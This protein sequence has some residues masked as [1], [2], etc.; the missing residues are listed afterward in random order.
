MTWFIWI[1][2]VVTWISYGITFKWLQDLR[3]INRELRSELLA[4][5]EMAFLLI[6][7]TMDK[8]P[9]DVCGGILH[10]NQTLTARITPTA[11]VIAH[12]MCLPPGDDE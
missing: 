12:A 10:P 2:L 4:A 11:N 3:K 9:C 7:R 1:C 8:I 6:D 5:R